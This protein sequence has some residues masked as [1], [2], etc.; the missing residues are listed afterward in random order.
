MKEIKLNTFLK[1][2]A[3]DKLYGLSD[4]IELCLKQT[5]KNLHV[6][7][8][9]ARDVEVLDL[10]KM[11]PKSNLDS[12]DGQMR[13]IH[14]LAHIEMQAMELGLRTLTEFPE[15]PIEFKEQLIEVIL[16]ESRHFKMLLDCLEHHK[17]PWGSYPVHLS[18]WFAT[19]SEDSLLD[20]IL[21]VH[22]Y[23]EGSGLDAGE[24]ITKKLW[25]AGQKGLLDI[26]KVIVDEEVSHVSFG[27]RWFR[28]LCEEQKMDSDHVFAQRMQALHHRLPKRVLKLNRQLRTE[29]GFTEAEMNVLEGLNSVI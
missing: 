23:L 1:S 10:F 28:K 24:K 11:P 12:V 6:P 14:D 5:Q 4:D 26:V 15:A 17:R 2:Q 20:R 19:S 18:L 9:P 3:Q 8:R 27:S 22:R 29:A 25:G 21:I 16:D 13:L 7:Q